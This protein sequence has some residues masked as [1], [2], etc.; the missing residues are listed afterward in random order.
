[1]ERRTLTDEQMTA[2]LRELLDRTEILDCLYRYTRG[3]DRL[4]RDLVSSAYHDDAIDEHGGFVGPVEEF[5]DW[6]FGYHASQVRHQHYITNHSVEIAGDEAHAE[7]YYLFIGTERDSD[8]PLTVVGGRYVD[9][10][11]RRDGRWAIAARVT[12][13]EWR[14]NLPS[15][16]PQ[17]AVEALASMGMVVARDGSDTSYDRPLSVK[18]AVPAH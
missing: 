15:V 4:D 8:V 5:L 13:V 14:T 11:E 12:L 3:M 6:A 2:R 16:L 1:M 17:A 9:R 7:S 10:F 18:R